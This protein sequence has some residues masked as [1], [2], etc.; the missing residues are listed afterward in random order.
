MRQLD[1][2][3]KIVYFVTIMMTVSTDGQLPIV[4]YYLNEYH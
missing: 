1:I 2:P 3:P 4:L